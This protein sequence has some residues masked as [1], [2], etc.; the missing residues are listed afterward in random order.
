MKS[1]SEISDGECP[2]RFRFYIVKQ[3]QND[4]S[5]GPREAR[6]L[7]WNRTVLGQ[8]TSIP[9]GTIFSMKQPP[10]FRVAWRAYEGSG[11][12]YFDLAEYSSSNSRL[13]QFVTTV[14]V[15]LPSPF[16]GWARASVA[17]ISPASGT[18]PARPPTGTALRPKGY[19]FFL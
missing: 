19:W 12:Y 4:W 16:S 11:K 5:I 14:P 2:F 18:P 1:P 7:S 10:W 8:W 6:T 3:P 17:A 9:L 13:S 15:L